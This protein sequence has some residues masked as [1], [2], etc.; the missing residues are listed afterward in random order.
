MSWLQ[1]GSDPGNL[2]TDLDAPP[3]C[4][5][6]DAFPDILILNPKANATPLSQ[7]LQ[8]VRKFMV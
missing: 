1:T 7:S 3:P 5:H 6:V 2:D 8:E 4:K